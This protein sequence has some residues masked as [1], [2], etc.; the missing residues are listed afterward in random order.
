MFQG[1]MVALVTPMQLDGSID[2]KALHDLVEWHIDAK[3]TAL[4]VVGTT[5][6][7]ATLSRPEQQDLIS[8]VVKQVAGRIPVIAGNWQQLHALND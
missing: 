6:E 8:R 1:S 2:K 3:T 5:G 4:I 7:A